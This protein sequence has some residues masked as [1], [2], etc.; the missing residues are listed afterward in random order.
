MS[1]LSSLCAL[2]CCI[3]IGSGMLSV[4][5]PGKR[6]KR[7]MGFV[8][9]LFILV[10]LINGV[11][12]C[13]EELRISLDPL[14]MSVMSETDDSAYTEAVVRQTAENLVIAADELLQSEGISADDIRVYIDV[15]KE[16]RIFIS[17]IS[18]YITKEYED[19]AE[20]IEAVIYRNFS[21]EPDIY[22]VE[23]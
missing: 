13:A 17:R 20:D 3:G 11:I 6:T 1:A 14:D 22:A 2:I 10:S 16:G 12:A 21:K 8:I 7:V 23:G 19:R 4:L 18:I 9:G 15:S 5:M